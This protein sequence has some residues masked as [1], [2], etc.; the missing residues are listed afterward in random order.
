[1]HATMMRWSFVLF[2]VLASLGVAQRASAADREIQV[3]L[4]VADGNEPTQLCVVAAFIRADGVDTF[5]LPGASAGPAE[6][7]PACQWGRTSPGNCSAYDHTVHQQLESTGVC[8]TDQSFRRPTPG[9]RVWCSPAP[10]AGPQ[11]M[12][13][14]KVDAGLTRAPVFGPSLVRLTVDTPAST[15]G[16]V[17]VEIVGGDYRKTGVASHRERDE[18]DRARLTL[19]PRCVSTHVVIPRYECPDGSGG[20]GRMRQSPVLEVFGAPGQAPYSVAF[21]QLPD[22]IDLPIPDLERA[23]GALRLSDCGPAR[24]LQLET[25]WP[26]QPPASVTLRPKVFSFQWRI[27]T[28]AT[29]VCPNPVTLPEIPLDCTATLLPVGDVCYYQCASSIPVDLPTRVE[30]QEFVGC[31]GE[32]CTTYINRWSAVVLRSGATIDGYLPPEQRFIVLDPQGW[33]VNRTERAGDQIES[34]WIAT[35]DGKGQ[36]VVPATPRLFVPGVHA[37][38]SVTYKYI[39]DRL[40]EERQ[41]PVARGGLVQL[42]DPDGTYARGV[43]FG[44]AAWG[45]WRYLNGPEGVTEWNPGGG[46]EFILA[47]PAARFQWQKF[48]IEPALHIGATI[49]SHSYE[50]IFQQTSSGQPKDVSHNVLIFVVP[51]DLSARFPIIGDDFQAAVGL[52]IAWYQQMYAE[53][54]NRVATNIGLSLPRVTLLWHVTRTISLGFDSRVIWGQLGPLR[55]RRVIE[56][57]DLGGR[58]RREERNTTMVTLGPLIRFDDVF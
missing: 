48:Y 11:R 19:T 17:S 47:V 2:V 26:D 9:L 52:G 49:T 31:R 20:T 5:P 40:F 56:T 24:L 3:T 16:S 36:F 51:I 38:D 46:A 39:G 42:E 35:P 45:G 6:P 22:A 12:L 13:A 53:D 15:K 21:A 25:D 54:E 29:G 30:F 7:T 18:S 55:S 37:R 41:S 27:D 28:L 33:K 57:F 23:G 43:Q 8:A 4:D 14:L 34:I 1:M 10:S 58:E 32:G 50:S 44:L